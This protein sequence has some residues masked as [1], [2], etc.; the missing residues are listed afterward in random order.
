MTEENQE[1]VEQVE[2]DEDSFAAGFAEARGDEPPTEETKTVE[3]QV[4]EPVAQ[5]PQTE[6]PTEAPTEAPQTVLAGLTEEQVKE[7]LLKAGKYDE[8]SGKVDSEIRKLHGR[9]GELNQKV[10]S[11][12]AK[13]SPEKMTRLREQ[14][15]E[16][17]DLL[18]QD[19]S[20]ALT[21]GQASGVDPQAIDQL[22][23]QRLA[24]QEQRIQ[25]EMEKR[26]LTAQHRDW[27]DIAGSEDFALW[28]ATQPD[29][30]K[31]ALENSWDAMFLS[32]KLTE[33]K[34]WKAAATKS[35]ETKQ[36]RLEAAVLP[37]GNSAPPS[38]IQ[39]EEAAFLA[40]FRA[41]R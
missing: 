4:E 7:L 41:A 23:N 10:Q 27:K 25:Q 8:L 39:D 3:E 13:L 19:L 40:A 22:M 20:E 16:L 35:K 6:E 24:V 38:T 29:D 5:E 18:V 14:Y 12:G 17:A 30:V 36:K 28:K 11:A 31:N 32:D 33:F 2:V 21:V 1:V 9:F 37:K 34:S 15:P 26:W